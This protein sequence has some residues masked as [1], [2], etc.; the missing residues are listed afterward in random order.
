MPGGAQNYSTCADAVRFVLLSTST[1]HTI[2]ATSGANGSITPSGTVTVND[3]ANQAFGISPAG[4]YHVADVLVDGSSVGAVTSYT[5]TNVTANHTIAASFEVDAAVTHTITATSGA[6]G[7]ITPSGTVTV[8]DGANQAFGIS[9]AGGY[10]VADVLVDGSSVGAVTSYTFTNV[11]AN[12]TIAASFEVDTAVTHTITAT[13]GAN[14]SITPSGTVTV[15]D[16]ANQAFSISPAGGYH[17]ADVLVDGSS[18]G[19]VTSYTFT[20]VTA[21]HTIAASFD[22]DASVSVIIDNG[23]PQTS[24]TGTWQVSGAL[25]PWDPA[26]SS[27]TSLWSRNGDTYTWTFTPT[28]SGNYEFSM[29]WTQYYSR[30]D[31]IPVEIESW[32][33]T[34]TIYIN[35]QTN[36]GQ[37]NPIGTYPFVANV[38]YNITITAAPGGTVNYSTCADAVKFVLVPSNV[39]PLATIGSVNPNPVLPGQ[40]VTFSGSGKDFEGSVAGYSW[41]STLDGPLS[42]QPS[43]STSTLS[44]GVH[45]ILFKVRDNTGKW[46]SEA[47]VSLDVNDY[48]VETTADVFFAAGYAPKN[49]APVIISTLQDM[50]ATYSNGVWTY[51]DT[52]RNKRY[53][54][55]QVT[56]IQ[57]LINA[58]N[59]QD[60][61]VLYNGHSNY[62]IGQLFATSGEFASAVI[63]D[64]RYV[65]DDRF[66]NSSSPIVHVN[67]NYMRTG[68]AYPHWWPIYKD[69]SSAIVPYDWGDP[70][71]KDP[72]YNY[73]P[74]YQ[75]PGDPTHYKIETVRNSA[76]SRFP[77]SRVPAWY[78]PDGNLPDPTNPDDLQ[79]YIINSDPW[80][81]SFERIGNWVDTNVLTG[82]FRENYEYSTAGTGSNQAKWLFSIPKD[83]DYNVYAWYPAS[84]SN[85]TS[86]P[87]TVNHA[88]G[89]TT[90]PVNQRL[91]GGQW[92]SLGTFHFGAADYSVVL[93]NNVSSGRVIADGIRVEDVNNPPETL[94]AHFFATNRS[95]SAPLIV[96]FRS[97]AV[98][99][100]D[101]F[102]WDFGDGTG[103]SSRD[104]VEHTYTA[105]GT[106]TVTYTVNGPLGSD[107]TTKVGYIVVGVPEEPLQ[108]EFE[109]RF[110]QTG[111]AP[112]TIR[113]RDRSTGDI[114]SWEWDFDGDGSIDS[115]EQSPSYT[116]TT[117]GL[118]TVSLTVKD[119]SANANT[120]TKQNFIRIVIF[121]T[122]IDNVDYPKTH[123]GSKTLLSRKV[124]E[125]NPQDFKFA[126]LFYGGCD[127]RIYYVDTFHRGIMHFSEGSTSEGDL[128]MAAYLKTYLEGKS[129][130]EIWQALQAIEPL[131]DY[132]D[133]NKPPSEQW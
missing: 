104:E 95:G 129:D 18:V 27:P 30:S 64:L 68:Q 82:F 46:S 115:T 124:L 49:A 9:P 43:F 12:H 128:E 122:N 3:G 85:S 86:A 97:E 62:G 132:F 119:S 29:W 105:P 83:G 2:T 67:V 44:E 92:N 51:R 38:S 52:A 17:V 111:T 6:N 55:H 13:S 31:N 98:G 91:N 58:F 35:Q 36:G 41:Y 77:D 81:P 54:I 103:N 56:T 126:R 90:V 60:A 121:D 47:Q 80:S 131:F 24:H 32:N 53:I 50:G 10:H 130:Y 87:Y 118:Y 28:T 99:D 93:T 42:D 34:N 59:T 125:V 8:N 61:I 37:W 113:F 75:V 89:S 11:T 101:T 15:N 39:A 106:Y 72:A 7:S 108:A 69:G 73:Y 16:G 22:S 40:S 117:P 109:S 102:H 4:G 116:Y 26:A 96:D 57:Q 21:N 112:Q 19:A 65:D 107:T 66:L 76:I 1:S 110:S 14:G 100:V 25:D 114:V 79:Y 63:D 45:T 20:N 123:Y 33:G 78:D 5:F 120:I 127:T 48:R 88:S 74:T 133:F 70:S 84:S 23:D 94:E 71:G